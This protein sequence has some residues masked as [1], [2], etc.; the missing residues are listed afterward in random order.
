MSL[1]PVP[2]L[3]LL[4]LS[5]P[6]AAAV[7]SRARAHLGVAQH[8]L[9][10]VIS[11]DR[12]PPDTT[13]LILDAEGGGAGLSGLVHVRRARPTLPVVC[14]PTMRPGVTAWLVAAAR[15]PFVSA[16]GYWHDP[17]DYPRL[18]ALIERWL[19]PPTCGSL[20]DALATR[21]PPEATTCALALAERLV[22]LRMEGRPAT[23]E[24][25]A[26]EL[27]IPR[28]TLA[29]KLGSRFGTP[30]QFCDGITLLLVACLREQTRQGWDATA[31]RLGLTPSAVRRLRHRAVDHPHQGDPAD[32]FNWLGERWGGPSEALYLTRERQ[33]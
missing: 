5:D 33:G 19:P 11:R 28:R 2:R 25:L 22:H 13:L 10:G 30:K 21:I 20:V 4:A 15:M 17:T 26:R 27:R 1:H 23:V 18:R 3:V 31:L 29:R 32:L 24:A 8:R 7:A 6:D 16:T 14:F 9:S 12:L